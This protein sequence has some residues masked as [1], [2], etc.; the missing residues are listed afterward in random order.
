MELWSSASYEAHL[1]SLPFALAP[2]AMLIVITYTAVMRGAP[3]LRGYLLMHCLA[4]LPYAAVMMLSPSIKS[5]EVAEQLFRIAAAFIPLAAAAGTGFQL[6]LIRKFRRYRLFVWFLLGNS[7][8]WLVVG[9]TS[10]AAVQGVRWLDG[11]W[12]PV[13]GPWTWL[14]LLH[15]VVLSMGGFIALAHA[16][17]TSKPS[18]ERRQWRAALVANIVT[19]AGLT[20]VGLAYGIGIFPLGWLL[21]GIGSLLVVRALVVEDLLRV[22]AVDTTAPLL[23]VHFAGAVV[24]GWICLALLGDGAPW[25]AA[26]AVLALCF[27][28]IRNAIVTVALIDRGARGSG[29][30]LDRLLAQLVSRARRMMHAPAIAQLAIDIIDLGVGVRGSVLIA[31]EEDWGWTSLNPPASLAA[32]LF[33]ET[34]R[35]GRPVASGRVD[36][37]HAPDP[38]LMS[39]LADHR[40]PLFVDDLEP[41]PADLRGVAE[42]LFEHH[43]ARAIIPVRSTDEILALIIL[44][45]AG[46]RLRGPAL[47]FVVRVAERLA[48]ALLHARMAQR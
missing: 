13:A 45:V 10:D 2:A 26:T 3:L 25:W 31:S 14:A 18:L 32:S 4:L 38:L 47:A 33:P 16:A 15:T 23:V 11:Y 27:V 20:D 43:R 34:L 19:Y 35:P 44:P 6:A 48:E 30:P 37:A 22:R 8:V 29:G 40:A 42:Q 7:L 17:L 9:S 36:D 41:V 28:G 1:L 12:Y 21:S 5:P 46:A 24:L 39:W